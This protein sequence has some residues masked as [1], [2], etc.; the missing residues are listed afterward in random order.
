MSLPVVEPLQRALHLRSLELFGDLAARE[1]AVFAGLMGERWLR[2]G[3]V[4]FVEGQRVQVLY[5]LV[6]GRVRLEQGGTTR[7]VEAP[8]GVGLIE[9]LARVEARSRAVAATNALAL[10][11]EGAALL[12]VLEDHFATFLQIRAALGLRVRDLYRR[13]GCREGSDSTA[14][15]RPAPPLAPAAAEPAA[16][17]MVDQLIRLHRVP[18]LRDFGVGVLAALI[19]DGN[20]VR[21]GAGEGLWSDDDE[22]EFLAVV[23]DGTVRC[24]GGDAIGRFR[25]GP[26]AV[27]GLPAAFGGTRH[28]YAAVAET[29][30]VVIR[31]DVP[32]LL[33]VA[34]DHFHVATSMLAHSART[35]LRLQERALE[36]ETS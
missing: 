36:E 3:E 18:E 31:V 23:V 32:V 12:E 2:R 20:A 27:L 6:E 30:V 19:R 13:F 34:E 14:P 28:L 1:L 25:V 15:P 22:A 16:L 24:S 7:Y 5:L 21:F 8:E 11:I 26:G 33:D 17:A 9:L 10:A 4:L 29:A 35:L